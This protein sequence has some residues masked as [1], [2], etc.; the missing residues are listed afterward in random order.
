LIINLNVNERETQIYKMAFANE[1]DVQ[2]VGS[3]LVITPLYYE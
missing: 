1:D 2:E 3:L